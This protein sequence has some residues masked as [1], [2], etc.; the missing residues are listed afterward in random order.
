M[1]LG[2]DQTEDNIFVGVR[3]APNLALF[4]SN[5]CFCDNILLVKKKVIRRHQEIVPNFD[6]LVVI[7]NN[8][9]G[10]IQRNL[11]NKYS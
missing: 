5:L 3:G 11:C 2:G 10:G 8:C 4:R 1:V 7:P 9:S 6:G